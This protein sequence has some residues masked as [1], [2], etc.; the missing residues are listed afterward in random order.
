VSVSASELGPPPPLPQACPHH[1]N[2]GE[3]LACWR[4]VP[5][6]TTGENAWHSVYSVARNHKVHIF[7]QSTTVHVPSP[8]L[9][10][11]HPLSR[12][13]VHH[14][15][16]LGESQF[17]RLEKSS[18]LCLLCGQEDLYRGR[19]ARSTQMKYSNAGF[20]Q[21]EATQIQ[22]FKGI[23]QP[24]ELGGETRLIRSAVKY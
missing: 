7:I 10:L 14:P 22:A 5:I 23:V 9:G 19:Q 6:R 2:Q 16:P 3:P 24:F 12:Q 13:C 4:G 18:A 8:E 15:P 20:S 21:A 11:S 1:R 17:R